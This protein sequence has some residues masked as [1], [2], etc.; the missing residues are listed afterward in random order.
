MK[1]VKYIAVLLLFAA[2]GATA[3]PKNYLYAQ[4]EGADLW[5]DVYQP[6]AQSKNT[7]VIYVFGGGFALGSTKDEGNV[8]FFNDLAARGYTVVAIDYRLGLKGV[9]S[10]GALNPKP[11]FAAVRLAAEDLV[12]ATRYVI[13]NAAQLKIDPKRIVLVGSSAGA[14][15]VLQTDYE[16]ANRTQMVEAL[17]S[18]FRYAGVVAMAGSVFS[19]KGRPQYATPPAPT[20]FLHGTS[21]KVVVYKKIQ[22]FHLGMFGTDVLTRIFAENHYPYLTIRYVGN[23][24]DVAEFPRH[25]NQD[26]IC[27]FIDRAAEGD[28]RNEMDVTVRD[29]FALENYKIELKRK[30]LYNG[31]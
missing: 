18:D 28:Y 14:I 12:S 16:L 19:T 20:M 3:Q 30:D 9:R 22:I 29:K 26:Q 13:D 4:K 23:K 27:D 7:C 15:T 21:D 1:T 24:H 10:V 5:L 2:L 6:Q 25:Y 17:P 11:A 31:N 8:R